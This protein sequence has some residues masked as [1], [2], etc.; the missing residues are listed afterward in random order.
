MTV[1]TVKQCVLTAAALTFSTGVLAGKPISINYIEDIV[2][3]DSIYSHYIVNCSN[4]KTADISAWDNRNSW[5]VG[6]GKRD[7]CTRTQIKTAKKVCR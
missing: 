1:V 7:N 4:G 3:G 6:K 2:D 5:C